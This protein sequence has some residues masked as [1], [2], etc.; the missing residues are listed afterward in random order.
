MVPFKEFLFEWKNLMEKTKMNNVKFFFNLNAFY[1]L[2][3]L[4]ALY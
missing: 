1:E 2:T 3:F 4:F